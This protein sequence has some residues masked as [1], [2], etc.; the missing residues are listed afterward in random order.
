MSWKERIK[1]GA[2]TTPDGIRYVFE[3]QD[4]ERSFEKKTS[5]YQFADT[6]GTYVQ[7]FGVGKVEYPIVIFFS[8]EDYDKTADAFFLS[9]LKK[10]NSLFESPRY[11]QH[12]VV[13]KGSPQKDAITSEGNQSSFSLTMTETIIVDIPESLPLVKSAIIADQEDFLITNAE[14]FEAG[15]NVDD[16]GDS[17]SSKDRFLALVAGFKNIFG[18]LTSTVEELNNEFTERSDYI[19]NNIDTLMGQPLQLAGAIQRLIAAPARSA[20]SVKSRIDGYLRTYDELLTDIQGDGTK[21]VKNKKTE[22]QLL[23][24]SILSAMAEVYLFSDTDGIGFLTKTDAVDAALNLAEQYGLGQEYLDQQQ[25]DSLGDTLE[26]RFSVSGSVAQ[27]IKNITSMTA[28]DLI[29]LSFSLKQERII[30]LDKWYN[31]LDLCFKLYG[32]TENN[33]LDFF[34]ESNGLTGHEIVKIPKNKSIVYY[35]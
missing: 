24:T 29:R 31:I 28:K 21:D 7:D 3:W 34:L 19:N 14:E 8:G 11:G 22:K 6:E 16:V 20:Q 27:G 26:N 1:E 25:S 30:I 2:I 15:F 35:V 13:I 32:T 18:K 17:L 12:D 23:I 9:A 33:T 5:D 4:L 10:G